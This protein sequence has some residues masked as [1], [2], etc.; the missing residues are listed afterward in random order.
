M[1]IQEVLGPQA[2]G[3]VPNASGITPSQEARLWRTVKFKFVVQ[4]ALLPCYLVYNHTE[5]ELRTVSR[6]ARA[7]FTGHLRDLVA[8]R[9]EA[10]DRSAVFL[11]RIDPT[12]N[13][14]TQHFIRRVDRNGL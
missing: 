2:E 10:G 6:A 11:Q 8:T 14:V 13:L 7:A 1:N 5:L 3:E 9:A 4:H 12:P